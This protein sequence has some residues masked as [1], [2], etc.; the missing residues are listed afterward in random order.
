M[1]ICFI[2]DAR[3]QI[4]RNWISWFVGQGHQICVISTYLA[5]TDTIP[6]AKVHTVPLMVNQFARVRHNGNVGGQASRTSPFLAEL[7]TGKLAGISNLI[8]YWAAPMELQFHVRRIRSVLAGFQPDIV[9][10]MRIPFEGMLA[11]TAVVDYPLLISIWGN[12]LTLHATDFRMVARLTRRT[13]ERADA[14]HCDCRRDSRLAVDQ[15]GFDPSKPTAVLPGGGGVQTDLFIRTGASQQLRAELNIPTDAPIVI[16]PRGFRGYVRNDTFF[17]AIPATLN[18]HPRTIFLAV[19]MKDSP[20]AQRW[21]DR[22]GIRASV[23]L[24]GEQSRSQMAELFKIA[25]V[26]VSITEHDGLPNTLLESLAC[27]A[28]PVVG[29]V[30]SIREWIEHGING[31]VV[32]PDDSEAVASALVSAISDR[33][34]RQLAAARNRKMI[35]ARADHAKVMPLAEKF[36]LDVI[37]ACNRLTSNSSGAL[38]S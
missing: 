10:A 27:G 11:A 6:G 15:W 38:A 31:F 12:D 3:S 30:E 17:K 22:L 29:D 7:R 26:S 14:L 35:E 32:P 16:N 23:R 2:T 36:Y 18:A 34:L 24:L 9:H 13:L 19:G 37:S 5:A 28:F 25:C 1:R 33:K 21:V 20:V 4:A 8:R